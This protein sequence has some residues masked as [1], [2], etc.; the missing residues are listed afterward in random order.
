MENY[1]TVTLSE[2]DALNT[3]MERLNYWTDDELTHD[4]FEQMYANHIENG[5]FDGIE[6][7]VQQIVDNDY[8][9]WCTII[10]DDHED[11]EKLLELYH[12][13]EYDISGEDVCGSY[14]EAVD[15][16]YGTRAILVRV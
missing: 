6:F 10:Y 14:I 3:L 15:S 7:D 16:Y 4:L 2:D 13:G 1:I 9:N 11:F 12:D 5:I 8:I